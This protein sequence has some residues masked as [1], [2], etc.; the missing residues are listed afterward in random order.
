MEKI[1]L[2]PMKALRKLKS[3]IKPFLFKYI[4]FFLVD[5]TFIRE[6]IKNAGANLLLFLL[7]LKQAWNTISIS[8][9]T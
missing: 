9:N 8:Y 5:R 7:Y 1:S 3:S 6:E 4:Q 2:S